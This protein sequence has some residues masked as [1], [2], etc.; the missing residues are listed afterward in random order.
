MEEFYKNI[1]E[2]I[3]E[4]HTINWKIPKVNPEKLKIQKFKIIHFD[5]EHELAL[6]VPTDEKLDHDE[7]LGTFKF[8]LISNR[9]IHCKNFILDFIRTYYFPVQRLFRGHLYFWLEI[10]VY[11]WNK[12]NKDNNCQHPM[13]RKDK[14][15]LCSIQ[16]IP[17]F[18]I[19]LIYF[20]AKKIKLSGKGSRKFRQSIF[21]QY[22]NRII[23]NKK[24][25]KEDIEFQLRFIFFKWALDISKKNYSK[26]TYFIKSLVKK[27]GNKLTENEIGEVSKEIFT[28]IL[29]KIKDVYNPYSFR[30]YILSIINFKVISLVREKYKSSSKLSFPINILNTAELLQTDIKQ[31]YRLIERGVIKLD[32]LYGYK[33]L[34]SENYYILEEYIRRKENI[35]S[36]KEIIAE[37]RNI[38]IKSAGDFIRRR[39]NKGETTKDILESL[40]L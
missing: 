7:Y 17:D 9:S 29:Q 33:K 3:F 11:N 20:L 39:M 25:K 21:G 37:K 10:L 16:I 22:K 27:H 31:I 36:F 13:A 12:P 1:T 26:I 6:S 19:E 34:D 28:Y 23:I 18:I 32:N 24:S 30:S 35:K 14:E 5:K 8:I 15:F 2:N 4:W 40:K 38:K